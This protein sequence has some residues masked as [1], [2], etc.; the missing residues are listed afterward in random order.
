[1]Q[2]LE[3]GCCF[4]PSA[5]GAWTKRL[6]AFGLLAAT[7]LAG[8]VREAPA[9]IA[10]QPVGHFATGDY[11]NGIA[12]SRHYAYLAHSGDGLRIFDILD[13]ASPT[14]VGH[15]NVGGY[16]RAVCVSGRF[17]FL[18]NDT[19]GLR[20]FDISDPSHPVSL[21][22]TN[23]GIS[24]LGVAVSGAY[25]YLANYTDGLRVYE[26]SD[27][28]VPKMVGHLSSSGETRAVKIAGTRAFLADGTG[29][30]RIFDISNPRAPAWLGQYD[31][32]NPAAAAMDVAISG[33]YAFLASLYGGF[34]ILNVADPA[35]LYSVTHFSDGGFAMRVALTARHCFVGSSTGLQVYDVADPANV[36]WA[37]SAVVAA[38]GVAF[39][40]PFAYVA[41]A[42]DGLQVYALAPQLSLSLSPNDRLL[43]SWPA[44]ALFALQTCAD[45]STGN[46]TTF[47]NIPAA[48]GGLDQV[49]L[50]PPAGTAFYRLKAW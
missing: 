31:D 41:A 28:T 3:V 8:A 36:F 42:A 50:P 33:D 13:P 43:F 35:H 39:S 17:A 14:N 34:R 30:L 40:G 48:V 1:V 47:T 10:L 5:N 7:L 29:G 2:A 32:P 9:Q 44:P 21:G 16:A 27:P 24:A 49:I 22:H 12:I 23:N 18:A 20:T 19:D 37:G 15:I 11:A 4:R 25:A 6:A 26:V 38:N 45:L 46:W